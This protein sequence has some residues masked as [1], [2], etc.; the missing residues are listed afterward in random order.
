MS[1]RSS[2]VLEV[3]REEFGLD[4]SLKSS[5]GGI[6]G[7]SSLEETQTHWRLDSWHHQLLHVLLGRAGT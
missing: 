4:P 3:V 7:R 1:Y 6:P 2:D 5:S